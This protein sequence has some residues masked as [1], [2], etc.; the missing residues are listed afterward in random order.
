MHGAFHIQVLGKRVELRVESLLPGEGPAGVSRHPAHD[1]YQR[2]LGHLLELID[3]LARDDA[4]EQVDV[5]LD[6]G[7]DATSPDAGVELAGEPVPAAVEGAVRS[8][9]VLRD[10]VLAAL[11]LTAHA[12]DVDVVGELVID[13]E[14]IVALALLGLAGPLSAAHSHGP[15]RRSTDGPAGHVEVVNVLLA[16]VVTR[17]PAEVVPV[18]HLVLHLG[19]AG[20]ALAVPDAAAVPVDV[21]RHDLAD[22]PFMD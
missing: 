7:I 20:L 19:H 10:V 15:D 2:A 3:R 13:G 18:V 22:R 21:S 11:D 17:E 16:D 8:C 6:V 12:H 14:L 1:R 4:L 5:L 9:D